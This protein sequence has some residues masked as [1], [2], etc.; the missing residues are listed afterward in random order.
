MM[1]YLYTIAGILLL[2]GGGEALVKG[3]V[4]LGLHLRLSTLVIGMTVVSL[5]TSAPELL[6]SVMAAVQGHPDIALGN[7]IGSNIANIG[8]VLGLVAAI[9]TLHVSTLS[10]R[11]NWPGMMLITLAFMVLIMDGQLQFWDGFLLVLLLIGFNSWLILRSK[12]AVYK[13][14]TDDVEEAAK[15]LYIGLFWLV[16]G[17]VVL[18]FGS[19]FLV[20]GASNIA[21]NFGVSDRVISISVVAIGTSLPELAASFVAAFRGERDLSIGNLLGSNIFNLGAVM[22]ISSMFH[23]IMLDDVRLLRVDIWW[24]LLFSAGIFGLMRW[25]DRFVITRFQGAALGFV[26]LIYMWIVLV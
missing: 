22:G 16:A 20:D 2:F 1:D 4:N 25:G 12:S 10:Y 9:F 6:V 26:Y 7:V 11:V 15:P 18:V 14:E 13:V 3:A 5:A 19:R 23:P 8:L 24:M 21:A 17:S